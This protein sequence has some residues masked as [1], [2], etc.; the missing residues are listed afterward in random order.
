[1]NNTL[2][3]LISKFHPEA[4]SCLDDA[5]KYSLSQR[6]HE[7]GIEHLLKSIILR[8]SELI[9]ALSLVS[10]LEGNGLFCTLQD[11]I[12]NCNDASEQK[13][14]FSV[15]LV[16]FIKAS[17]QF[18]SINWL[19]D[20]IVCSAFLA[21]AILSAD[22]ERFLLSSKIQKYLRCNTDKA[23]E[24]LQTQGNGDSGISRGD[25]RSDVE[26]DI[27]HK[28]T[29]NLTQLAKSGKLDPVL[30]RETEIRQVIDVLLRRRQNNP[31]LT[32]EP[33]VGKTALVEGL[34]Q[35]IV[36]G[37]VPAALLNMDVLALDL[38][39][40]QAGASVKGEFESR[41]DALLKAV[42]AH[43]TGAILFIDEAHTLIGAGGTAGQGDAA[44]ILKP[45]L[46]RGEIRVIAAT[47]WSEYKK[48][49]EKD[50]ALTRR[51]QEIKVEPPSME[52]A[53]AMLRMI[54]PLMERHHGVAI[55][56]SAIAAAVKLSER[57]IPARQL[58]DKAISLLDTACARVAVS[59]CHM[60][61]VIESAQAAHSRVK[62]ELAAW[63]KEGENPSRQAVLE[64]KEKELTGALAQLTPVWL[65]QKEIVS[66]L[67]AAETSGNDIDALRI[68]LAG[69]HENHAMVF[70]RVDV[71]CVADVI[72][73][74]TGIPC[75][76]LIEKDISDH[77]SAVA[78]VRQRIVGQSFAMDCITT[79]LK[80]C[81][82]RLNDPHKP[83]GVFMLA[84]PSGVG[85]TETA[86]ALA[87]LAY[88]G[89]ANL[90]TINMS[91]YQ[92]A[93]SVSGLK[94]SP[95]GYVGYGQGGVLTEAVRRRPYSVILLDEVEKAH[96]DVMEIFYQ[97]FD[98]GTMEDA[99]GQLI[100]FRNTLILMTTN[101]GSEE[102][103]RTEQDN[104][105]CCETIIDK[106]KP[107]FNEHFSP[108]FMGR[109]E[110]I[111]FLPLSINEVKSIVRHKLD[112]IKHR[113][114]KNN[115]WRV[116]YSQA[117]IDEL[118]KK[119]NVSAS[120]A[121]DIDRI[122]NMDLLPEVADLYLTSSGISQDMKIKLSVR[123]GRFIAV[124]D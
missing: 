64:A 80:I 110:L 22:D 118:V 111:P 86:I 60:P 5:V 85:K 55:M 100:N 116:V 113:L 21:V 58:P 73:E 62:H 45:A 50:A 29:S 92:E 30:G 44:N 18:S 52:T 46:A 70:E 61:H 40:L 57:Y 35:R 67:K 19:R 97:V 25:I 114:G 12:N 16:D 3:N 9:E 27:L 124:H 98:K 68:K 94:G 109:V 104:G 77:M 96:P 105:Y 122:I 53:E 23:L 15:A 103:S 26:Q 6:C 90:I 95:P 49:F 51:F 17:W 71:N 63:Q 11:E 76:R 32:G 83:T 56:E 34:A 39:L 74:W 121:R 72:S 1:M 2:K 37:S 24:F 101:L 41:L 89:S 13:P 43:P 20:D 59:Q 108:A 123:K 42:K 91:E 107:I 47:T 7:I 88:G 87:E 82:A 79:R 78:E 8:K 48:Y 84:G 120:G 28:Y 14:V 54:A 93:H 33:G 38:T 75:A 36:D 4:R 112:K 31:V 65:A 99:E 119:C 66:S 69:H 81:H 106:I 10:G 115:G 102:I 117:V